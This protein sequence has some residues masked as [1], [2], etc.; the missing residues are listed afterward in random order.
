VA[1]RLREDEL[2]GPAQVLQRQRQMAALGNS[3]RLAGDVYGY[4]GSSAPAP[5]A[6][7]VAAAAAVASAAAAAASGAANCAVPGIEGGGGFATE[8]F[9]PELQLQ[10]R[11][12]AQIEGVTLPG[13]A[14]RA[15]GVY[16]RLSR[17]E[18][19]TAS[20]RTKLHETQ[21]KRAAWDELDDEQR[22][23]NSRRFSMH[24]AGLFLDGSGGMSF[25]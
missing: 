11:T 15:G 9:D 4:G 17:P 21:A 5:P 2:A 20:A 3:G 22:A 16:D 6:A 25:A 18:A 23:D 24:S 13:C 10:H 7:A 12:L 1:E 19:S 8:G 14:N